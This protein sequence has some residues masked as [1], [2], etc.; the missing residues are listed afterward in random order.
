MAETETLDR[1]WETIR[2][3]KSRRRNL[4]VAVI[5]I[6]GLTAAV[7]CYHWGSQQVLRNAQAEVDRLD[8]GWRFEELMAKRAVVPDEQN[9]GLVLANARQ[10]LPPDWPTWSTARQK[11]GPTTE[12]LK[13]IEK[14]DAFEKLLWHADPPVLWDKAFIKMLRAELQR[15]VPA[16]AEAHKIIDMRRGRYPLVFARDYISTLQPHVQD[17]R[18]L[19]DMLASE[20]TLRALD[21]DAEGALASCRCIVQVGRSIGDEPLLLS[22]LERIGIRHVA[23]TRIEQTLALGKAR[24]TSLAALQRLLEEEEKE[25]L[26]LNGLRGARGCQ[27]ALMEGIA[28]G[29]VGPAQVATL[30]GGRTSRMEV[31]IM[32]RAIQMQRA[33]L[34]RWNS[35]AV[36]IAKLPVQEQSAALLELHA[37]GKSLPLLTRHIAMAICKMGEAW[38][39]SQ[40][41]LRCAI[42]LLAVERYRQDHGRWPTAL[43]E[44]VP[45]YLQAVPRDPRDGAPV[46]FRRFADG[47][48]IYSVGA[49]GE[50]NGGDLDEAPKKGKDW[51]LRLWD[52]S[53]RRQ[54]PQALIEK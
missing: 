50:D 22:V 34:L 6:G 40:A 8:P 16:L 39:H 54:P 4:R 26:F 14:L 31:L 12:E 28:N 35:R 25:P 15:A 19:A 42:T 11:V 9:S 7:L 1:P 30:L 3:A 43:S 24:S 48:M 5:L 29:D 38:I 33:A 20:A 18:T 47:V 53:R 10:L 36:E 45:E 46:R 21:Q 27:D 17:A 51:G 32:T 52:L 49:D 13:E 37:S 23:V 44:L 41:E 2:S